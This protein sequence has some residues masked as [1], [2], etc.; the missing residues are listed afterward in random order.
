M[1]P[2]QCDSF[3]IIRMG[4]LATTMRIHGFLVTQHRI[5]HTA[6]LE[7]VSESE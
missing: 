7:E 5:S 4:S 2:I 6:R 3:L 1:F